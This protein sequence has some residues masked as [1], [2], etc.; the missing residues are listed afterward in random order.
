MLR[1]V[2]EILTLQNDALRATILPYGATLSGLWRAGDAKSCVLGFAD[3]TDYARFPI[4]AGSIVGPVANRLG[5]GRARID[6]R[7]FQMPRNERGRTTLHSGP[8]GLHRRIWQVL[9]ATPTSVTLRIHLP[10]GACGLPGARDIQATYRLEDTALALD[11]DATTDAPTLMNP[12]H[13]PY[14]A[15]DARTRI[16]VSS[17]RYLPV[18]A[19]KLPTGRQV[20]V[21]DSPFDLRRSTPIPQDLDHAYILSDVADQKMRRVAWLETADYAMRL[22]TDAPSLQIYSGSGL[23]ELGTHLTTGHPIA[24]LRGL[25]IEPQFWPDAP[26]HAGFPSILLS[27]DTPWQQR[28]RYTLS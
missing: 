27:P 21:A 11:L 22:D 18:N 2:R 17:S 5:D 24:P 3:P 7:V 20:E 10:H 15:V 16:R 14:W 12:A 26:N 13:H 8:E 28:T 1:A 9:E 25:A 19:W 6:G 23:P 4:Y